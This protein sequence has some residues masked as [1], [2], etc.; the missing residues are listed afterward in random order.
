M[1]GGGTVHIIP[2]YYKY[3]I[4]KYTV[5]SPNGI[6]YLVIMCSS[7]R[8][9]EKNWA[10]GYY[11]LTANENVAPLSMCWELLEQFISLPI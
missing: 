2:L 3:N 8:H 11:T 9:D 10:T 7:R 5:R 1:A 4:S 6:A